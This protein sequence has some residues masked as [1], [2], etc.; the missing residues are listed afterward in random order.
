MFKG[1][2]K[3]SKKFLEGAR[4][5]ESKQFTTHLAKTFHKTFSHTAY[6][7]QRYSIRLTELYMF[8]F[9]QNKFI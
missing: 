6:M 2:C 1:I 5:D 4:H 8:V 9:V 3:S 7:K